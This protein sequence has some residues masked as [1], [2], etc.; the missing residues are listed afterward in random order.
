MVHLADERPLREAD[1]AI[2]GSRRHRNPILFAIARDSR[3]IFVT[4][5]ID[6]RSAFEKAIPTDRQVHLRAIAG[7]VIET[8]VAIEPMSGMQLLTIS[9]LHKSYRVEIGYFQPFSVW[10]S[11]VTSSD[12]E[13]PPQGSVTLRDVDL[14]T[15][16]FHLSFHQL[17]NLLDA[18]NTT[19]VARALSACQ[20]QL[21]G[22]EQPNESPISD[23][24]IVSGLNVSAS[25]MAAA[26]RDF[27]K[28]D[29]EKLARHAAAGFRVAAS[30]PAGGFQSNARC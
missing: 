15:I 4:W 26:G 27:E 25:D 6:W 14:A 2:V 29:V 23:T 19:S 5:N 9:G 28:I 17:A 12:I 24:R 30:S 3:T 18:A 11:V 7:G 1:D 21:P 10:H 20:K 13:P 22:S 16:P 8:A